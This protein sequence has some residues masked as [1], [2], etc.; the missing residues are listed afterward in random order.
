LSLLIAGLTYKHIEQYAGRIFADHTISFV[1]QRPLTVI[2]KQLPGHVSALS[3]AY[4]IQLEESLGKNFSCVLDDN[5]RS[6]F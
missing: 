5:Q 1:S 3:N 2:T 6:K 4:A